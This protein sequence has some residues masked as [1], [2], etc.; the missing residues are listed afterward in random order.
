MQIASYSVSDIGKLRQ[1]NQD[2]IFSSE[3]PVGPL[4]NLFIV[5]DG[6]G[7]YKGGEF[8][9]KCAVETLVGEVNLSQARGSVRI[10]RDAINVA[11]SKVRYIAGSDENYRGMGTTLVVAVFEKESMIVAN[12]G[13]SRLYRIGK[14]IRQITMDHSLVEE[15]VRM[16][17]IERTDARLHPD[18]N[19]I[20][21]AIGVLDVVDID[22]FEVEDLHVGD[23]ILMCSDGLCNMVEDTEIAGIVRSGGTLEEKANRLITAANLNGGRDNISVNL[24]EIMSME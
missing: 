18:K 3:I 22:F 13:D 17:Q 9:S 21:R 4:P 2:Y 16:G 23:M 11:N 10:L 7:G 15:M 24:I 1:Q 5:A 12:V 8:A 14:D 20:T 6:M 19:I